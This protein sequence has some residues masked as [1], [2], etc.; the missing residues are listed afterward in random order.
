[1]HIQSRVRPL[2]V[3]KIRKSLAVGLGSSMP[4]LAGALEDHRSRDA[5][6][7]VS[8]AQRTRWS[9]CFSGEKSGLFDKKVPRDPFA[10]AVQSVLFGV[11]KMVMLHLVHLCL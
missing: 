11:F 9:S 3:Q 6:D 7:K 2:Q 10:I 5:E 8:R 4:G 1:M